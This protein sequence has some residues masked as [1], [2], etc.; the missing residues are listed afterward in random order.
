MV[1]IICY[2]CTIFIP[3][4]TNENED[5]FQIIISLFND[6]RNGYMFV[7]NP[8]GAWADLMVYGGE[9]ENIDWNGVW[10]VKTS[11]GVIMI[12]YWFTF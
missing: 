2:L 7:I 5:N 9:E 8:N 11:I 10:D 3:F 4:I 12:D 1:I 6:K